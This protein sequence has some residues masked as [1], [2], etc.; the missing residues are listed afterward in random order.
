M[1]IQQYHKQGMMF[2]LGLNSWTFVKPIGRMLQ[3][4]MHYNNANEMCYQV[5]ALEQEM[6]TWLGSGPEECACLSTESPSDQSQILLRQWG[7]MT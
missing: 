1:R 4:I 2:A 6:Q 7:I 3:K 5:R